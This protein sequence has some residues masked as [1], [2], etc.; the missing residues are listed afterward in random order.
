MV[1]TQHGFLEDILKIYSFTVAYQSS[2]IPGA[3]KVELPE[4]RFRWEGGLSLDPF[5]HSLIK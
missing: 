5:C 3:K 2:G 1:A 4:L